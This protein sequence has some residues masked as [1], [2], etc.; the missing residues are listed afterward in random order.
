MAHFWKCQIVAWFL[1]A[2]AFPKKTFCGCLH[3]CRS[4]CAYRSS[5]AY[6]TNLNHAIS[7]QFHKSF[8]QILPEEVESRTQHVRPRTKKKI[9][10][11]GPTCEVRLSR[12]QG[13]ECSGQGHN[14]ISCVLKKKKKKKRKDHRA[15]NRKYFARYLAFSKKNKKKGYRA[16]NQ[17]R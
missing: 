13:Q 5:L 6:H 15:K 7:H 12:G 4:S 11:Q 14:L 17:G 3:H 2:R 10:G 8:I 16:K 9:R 1:R